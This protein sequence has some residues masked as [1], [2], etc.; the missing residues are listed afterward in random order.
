M[1][2]IPPSSFDSED[3]LSFLE[4]LD[5]FFQA[6]DDVF[7]PNSQ[8][9]DEQFCIDHFQEHYP[10]VHRYIGFAT[11]CHVDK[12]CLESLEDQFRILEE[13]WNR[14]YAQADG[15]DKQLLAQEMG[16][17][18]QNMT[19]KHIPEI[20]RKSL[21]LLLGIRE[22]YDVVHVENYQTI[23][24]QTQEFITRITQK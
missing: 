4:D 10:T 11:L 9:D 12:Y 17:R 15:R 3:T 23:V 7:H 24:Q 14:I 21:F 22:Y 1:P 5:A 18:L 8:Y 16:N 2:N 13:K 6:V 19:E 20:F